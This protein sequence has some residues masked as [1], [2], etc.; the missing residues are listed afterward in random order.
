M[1]PDERALLAHVVNGRWPRDAA[2]AVGMH[3][4]RCFRICEKWAGRGWYDFGVSADLGWLTEAGKRAA[5]ELL[6]G[7]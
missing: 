6:A 4:K 5:S 7:A 2:V 3:W 1:K